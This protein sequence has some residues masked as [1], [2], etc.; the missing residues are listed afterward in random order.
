MLQIGRWKPRGVLLCAAALALSAL[1]HSSD[2]AAAPLAVGAIEQVD[3][4]T[5]SIVVLGQRFYVGPA[6]VISSGTSSSRV[7]LGA[8]SPDTMAW[9]DGQAS[10]AGASHVD[11]VILLP[12]MSVP[13]ASQLLVT[14]VVSAVSSDGRIRVGQ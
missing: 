5:S 9:I 10:A 8:V 12:E 3:L 11:A 14:G 2:S 13:G 1:G 7:P 6:V 4:S